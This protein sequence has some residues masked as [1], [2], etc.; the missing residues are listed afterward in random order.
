LELKF[1]ITKIN[2]IKK[3]TMSSIQQMPA[4]ARVW[5]FQSNRV[6]CEVEINA[7]EKAGLQFIANWTAHGA[8]LKASFDI[9][10]NHF[11]IISVDEKQAAAG[12]CSVDKAIHF[13]KELEKQFNINLLDRMEVAYRKGNEI[14]TCHLNNLLNELTASGLYSEKGNNSGLDELIV[15]NNMVITKKQFDN[16]WEVPLK[17]S[18]Q[19]RVLQS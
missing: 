12:G 18:W 13:I 6:L 2:K 8:S 5:V 19:S 4:D 15:F 9:L 7:I 17:K 11:I 16:E 14:K 10:Y 1:V 3:N